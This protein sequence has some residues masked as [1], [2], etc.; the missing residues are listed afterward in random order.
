MSNP[1]KFPVAVIGAG[2]AGLTAAHFLR[3]NGVPVIL[4]EAGKQVAGMASSYVD[5]R[6]FHYDFG[7]HFITNRLAA[8]VG[9]GGQCRDVPYYGES[10]LVKGKTYSYPF[11]LM[12]VPRFVLG[13]LKAKLSGGSGA[14]GQQSA[15][16]W[17][18]S[19][20]GV[21]LADEVSLP[22]LEAWSG[23]SANELSASVGDKLQ[24]SILKT[25]YLRMCSRVQGR[26]TAIGYSHEMPE[27]PNVWHVYPEHGVSQVCERILADVRDIV[28]MESP[29]EQ[30]IVDEGRVVAIRAAGREREV[31][32]VV[33]TAPAPILPK[34]IVG[35][36]ALQPLTH[37]RYR[38][39]VFVCMRF[40][41][42]GIL[43]DTVLWTAGAGFPFFRLTET[44]LSMP[45]LAPDGKT[46]VTADIGCQVG[47]DI[48]KMD[49]NALGQRC[50]EAMATLFPGIHAYYSGCR[51]LRTPIAY[52]VYL[53]EYE[54]TR[55]QFSQGTGIEGLYSVGRNGE[56]AHILMEDV[57][58]RT[59]KKMNELIAWRRPSA[60]TQAGRGR[61][62]AESQEQTLHRQ[63]QSD[64]GKDHWLSGIGGR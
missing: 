48:W 51:I 61:S 7:A 12:T 22:I 14:T 15:L 16:D 42:R 39:M 2:I 20:F 52:P 33:S 50:V 18:R 9:I 59:I 56:F 26:A 4:F 25:I 24:N 57:Y 62:A 23:V 5:E 47:D 3:R 64:C 45:W 63:W 19:E 54:T 41:K 35:S 53:N 60:Q 31:S 32:A 37:F 55:R 29:V 30:I 8:A 13:G 49:D 44:P 17:F 27:G 43:S 40:E 10:F 1:S 21:A 38:P 36:D 11:G 46:L 6:G 34:L 58:W 28:E